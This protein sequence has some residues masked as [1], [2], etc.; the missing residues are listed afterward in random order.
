MT[1]TQQLQALLDAGQIPERDFAFTTSLIN[2][3]LSSRGAT[4]KQAEWIER[5]VARFSAPLVAAPTPTTSALPTMAGVVAFLARARERGLKF[6]KLWLRLP[7]GW[8][9][10]LSIAGPN[11]KTPGFIVLTDGEAF[12]SNRFYGKVSPAGEL[13]LG[14]DG[15]EVASDLT[16][17]L[18]RVAN[19]PAKVA[20]EFGHLT[21]HCCFCSLKLTDERS[22]FVGYGKTCAKKFGL[23]WGAKDEEVA[24]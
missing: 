9:L 22:T 17:L 10:R 6:P 7:N 23:A 8:D 18:T 16:T 19:E 14:R 21:G 3:S 13:R 11:S 15:N 24:A 2:A 20:S 5:L 12:G 1:P 4:L